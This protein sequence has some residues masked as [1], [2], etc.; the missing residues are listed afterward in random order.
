MDGVSNL[1]IGDAKYVTVSARMR[2]TQHGMPSSHPGLVLLRQEMAVL[3]GGAF[4]SK[5]GGQLFMSP[6][7]RMAFIATTIFVFSETRSSPPTPARSR[8]LRN[9]SCTVLTSGQLS[10]DRWRMPQG[11]IHNTSC[12]LQG[13]KTM[14]KKHKRT[15]TRGITP[16]SHRDDSLMSR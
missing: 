2:R 16:C 11:V 6:G 13:I 5:R 9:P 14:K 1:V 12:W 15:H 10:L 8:T 3:Q 7:K 4:V